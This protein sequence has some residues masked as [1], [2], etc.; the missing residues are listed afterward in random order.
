MEHAAAVV[1]TRTTAWRR[2]PPVGRRRKPYPRRNTLSA[3]ISAKA[4]ETIA[5]QS[6]HS[7]DP[8]TLSRGGPVYRTSSYAFRSTEHA[9]NLFA[10]KEF[11][12]IYSRLGNPTNEVL[13]TRVTEIEGGAASV[14]VASGTAAIFNTVITIARAGDEIVSASNLYGGTANLFRHTLKR[15][16]IEDH[17]AVMPPEPEELIVLR[18]EEGREVAYR[19]TPA[20]REQSH[21]AVALDLHII[22][23]RFEQNID[24]DSNRKRHGG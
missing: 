2:R 12:N 20:I 14:A 23:R 5:I 13:E 22:R 21:G 9:A 10:L 18:D 8:T 7:P 4:F 24:G 11:G 15:F 16:G 3:D 6:G 19:D 1:R 17:T